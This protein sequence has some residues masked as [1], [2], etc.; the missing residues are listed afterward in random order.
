[1]RR[2]EEFESEDEVMMNRIKLRKYMREL[3]VNQKRVLAVAKDKVYVQR[4]KDYFEM[5][6]QEEQVTEDKEEEEEEEEYESEEEEEEEKK[7]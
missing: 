7:E 3:V 1:M 6:K 4:V 2:V 5:K